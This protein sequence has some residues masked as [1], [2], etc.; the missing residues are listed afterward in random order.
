MA[1]HPLIATLKNLR[2]NARGCIYTEPLWGIPYNLYAPYISVYML[3]LGLTDSRI[4]LLTSIGLAFEVLWTILSGAIT[5]KLGRK[6]TT[7]IFDALSWSV[8]CLI[9]AIAQDFRYFLA[10]AIVNSVWRVTLN[11]WQCLLVEDTDPRLLVDVY[12]WIYIAGLLAAF[13]SPLTG[14]LIAQFSLVPTMRALYLLA[15]VMMTAKFLI[16]NAMVTETAQGM[17]RMQETAHQPL[18]AVLR[19][20]PAVLRQLLR[21]PAT[22]ATAALMVILSITRMIHGTFWA[23]LATGALAIPAE[24]LALFATA[25]SLIM[26]LFFFGAMPR[27]RRGNAHHLMIVGFLGLLV[28]QIVLVNAPAGSYAVL[29]IVTA[30]E[31]CSVPLASTLLDQMIVVTVDPRERARIMA[32][33]YVIVIVCTAPFGWVAGRMSEVN[34]SLPF[35]LNVGLYA[36]G[37]LLTYFARRLPPVAHAA[38]ERSEVAAPV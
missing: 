19:E 24:H 16:M 10:A 4:G 22:L 2:G 17:V 9:W 6:R 23:I 25:R 3:A 1:R 36:V 35:V 33:L 21:A 28:S 7:L 18:F 8:P 29:L 26:L 34:R 12:S 27:L 32:L 37:A 5:D 14:L 30:L 13:V 38:Q 15:F 20:Y 11:S 31:A